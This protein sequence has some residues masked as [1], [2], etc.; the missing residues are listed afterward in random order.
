MF[1]T[2]MP[3]TLD[4][5][6]EYMHKK[7]YSPLAGGTDLMIRAR[8]W[9]GSTRHFKGDVLLI[10]HLDSLKRIWVDEEAYHMG[11]LVTQAQAASSKVLPNY[12]KAVVSQMATPA[13]RNA[14]TLGG[15]IVNA[16]SVADLLPPLYLADARLVL[17]SLNETREISIQEFIVK[18]YTTSR[19]PDELLTEIILP[20]I[21]CDTFVYEKMGQRRASILS[22]VSFLAVRTQTDVR[23]AIGALNDT[24][25][26]SRAMEHKIAKGVPFDEIIQGYEALYE[27]HDDKRSTK[28]YKETVATN[29]LKNWLEVNHFE[30]GID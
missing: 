10:S 8:N 12:F 24:V 4:E 5:A 11:A 9:Q 7:T 13:I 28:S 17:R 14:A 26:R 30:K 1:E 20:K 27:S 2:I 23:V 16:A 6:L 29:L 21:K 19:R 3:S 15:N 25:I 18:K 22:K